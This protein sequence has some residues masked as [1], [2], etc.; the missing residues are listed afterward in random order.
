MSILVVQPVAEGI[1]FGADRNITHKK[2]CSSANLQVEIQGQ[3]QRPKVL[4]WPNNRALLGF[5]GVA[6]IGSQPMDEWLYN[7]IGRNYVFDNFQDLAILLKDEIQ[8]Q[9]TKDEGVNESEGLIIHLAGFERRDG[10]YVPVVWFIRNYEG[11]DET[12]GCYLNPRKEFAVSEELWH[13]NYIEGSTPATIR[14]YLKN[15]A[16]CFN[17]FWFHQGYGL[18]IFNTLDAFIKGSFKLLIESRIGPSFPNSLKEWENHVKMSILTYSAYF[19]SFY[20]PFEQYVGGG[21]D[22]VSLPWPD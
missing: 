16:E 20:A 22:V 14:S 21:A 8:H 1:I 13:E 10:F 7:F 6:S 12:T 5:V 2:I 3:S 19:Q 15:R 17:P 4:R 9:R 11:M 18:G